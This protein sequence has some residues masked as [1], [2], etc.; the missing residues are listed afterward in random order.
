M[1]GKNEFLNRK[2]NKLSI[3]S[4]PVISILILAV[5]SNSAFADS[6]ISVMGYNIP[7]APRFIKDFDSDTGIHTELNPDE[8]KIR[9]YTNGV[10]RMIIDNLGNVEIG[11]VSSQSI[12]HVMGP[13]L[14]SASTGP[15]MPRPEINNTRIPGEISGVT[16]NW[17]DCDS[18]FLRLS[19]GG[20]T[21]PTSKTFI[22]LTGYSNWANNSDMYK[23]IVFGTEGLEKMRLN[24]NGFLGIGTSN[25]KQKLHICDGNLIIENNNPNNLIY[26]NDSESK[27]GLAF[28]YTTD[29][30]IVII[31]YPNG[32]ADWNKELSYDFD[33][34]KWTVDS[35][36]IVNSKIGVG[37]IEPEA[38]LHVSDGAILLDNNKGFLVKRTDSS[39]SPL[40]KIGDDDF[41][42]IY[43]PTGTTGIQFKS[44]SNDNL[45]TIKNDGKIGIGTV[46]P[47]DKLHISGNLRL[48]G[49][50]VIQ[51][52][53]PWSGAGG[54][55]F[56]TTGQWGANYLFMHRPSGVWR[57]AAVVYAATQP[58]FRLYNEEEDESVRLAASGSSWLN[59]GNV[60][61]GTTTPGSTL[62]ISGSG[63]PTFKLQSD[64]S[65]NYFTCFNQY[66]QWNAGSPIFEIINGAT[67]SSDQVLIG[68]YAASG[69]SN[70]ALMQ[71]NVGIGTKN[72]QAKLDVVGKIQ[73][74]KSDGQ[75]IVEIGEG[76]DYAEG[77]NVSDSCRITPGSVLCIDPINPG[78]L[79]L[80]DQPYDKKVAGIV[81]GANNLSSGVRL[82]AGQFDHN[83]A[84]V[85]RV[86]CN[87]DATEYG[88]EPGDLLT[89]SSMP[90]YAMKAVDHL[91]AQGAIL[92]KA[93]E[94]LTKGE[95]G[96]ILVLVTLQ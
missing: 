22:D 59:G 21:N 45:M 44:V 72:P 71:G 77:F 88:I 74:S 25:P 64:T 39:I 29:N 27:D 82:S 48:G 63:S 33:E 95:I 12:F 58:S 65:S 11:K 2:K 9:F 36:F 70:T 28:R 93:M 79:K 35:D 55:I 47:D 76:L 49:Y 46:N 73:I 94:P 4:L 92:G 38:K 50:G 17:L 87:V 78:K 42:Q 20:G 60:G 30:R 8:D 23:N 1:N 14:L 75:A 24:N 84:L 90:G 85:G 67:G 5:L 37:T 62:E 26:L 31:P 43:S 56:N 69:G 61:I 40:I 6:S 10:Q 3:L 13:I 18:G 80:S 16:E 41:T 66:T 89:T 51:P 19:A 81:A 54:F 7:W 32:T 57:K 68:S 86:Y 91:R 15:E 53:E 96:Q 52:Y 83:V 34:G